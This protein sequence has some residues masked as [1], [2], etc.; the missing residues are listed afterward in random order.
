MKI[1]IDVDGVILDFERVFK[2]TSIYVLVMSLLSGSPT[3]A[4][5]ISNLYIN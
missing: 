1:G 4:V 5:I 2:N 3:S